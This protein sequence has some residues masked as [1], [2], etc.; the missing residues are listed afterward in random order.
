VLPIAIPRPLLLE[1]SSA[2]HMWAV[3][4][5]PF[6]ASHIALAAAKPFAPLKLNF[7]VELTG[8]MPQNFVA[9]TE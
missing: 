3:G 9:P 8:P 7:P 4:E 1:I 6:A 5:H 2:E